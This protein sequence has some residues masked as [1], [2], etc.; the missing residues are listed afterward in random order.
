[1]SDHTPLPATEEHWSDDD[2]PL[3]VLLS[4]MISVCWSSSHLDVLP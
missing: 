1:M 4:S 2:L 3:F